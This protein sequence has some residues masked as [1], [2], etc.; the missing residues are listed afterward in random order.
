[1]ILSTKEFWATFLAF[2]RLHFPEQL[3]EGLR[4]PNT[5]QEDV[6]AEYDFII[7][8]AGS[9][10]CVL[11]NRLS[12][13]PGW[14][15][16]LIEAGWRDDYVSD[17]P[18]LAEFLG[19][20]EKDWNYTTVKQERACL[21]TEGTCR[22]PKG[23]VIGGCST[24][25]W[26]IYNRGNREDYDEWERLGNHGWG[27]EQVL[28]YFKKA[29][30]MTEECLLGSNTHSSSGPLNV[31]YPRY[32]TPLRRD[33][34][35]AGEEIGWR[36]TDYNAGEQR[37]VIDYL[38]YTMNGP[39]RES[40]VKAYLDPIRSRKN[41]DIIM[42]SMVSRVLIE[43]N[44]ARGVE[45][46]RDGKAY[47][48]FAK[49]EVIL[50]TGAIETP[51]L[52]ML[53]GIGPSQELKKH[54]IG[55]LVDLPV[56]KYYQDHINIPIYFEVNEL[57][58]TV[59]ES[60]WKTN[61]SIM[62]FAKDKDGPLTMAP[63]G[64]EATSFFNPLEKGPPSVQTIYCSAAPSNNLG[65]KKIIK[66]WVVNIQP[67]S[68]GEIRLKSGDFR[69]PPLLD[70]NL[71]R[72]ETDK[73]VLEKGIER[74]FEFM[75]SETMSKYSPK[76][77]TEHVQPKCHGKEGSEYIGCAIAEYSELTDRPFGTAR[78]GPRGSDA[79][80]SSADL[81]VRGL[82]QLRV[83]DASV[84]P[85][86]PGANTNAP[87]IMIAEKAADIIRSYYQEYRSCDE[88]IEETE[89]HE[90]TTTNRP[91]P[92]SFAFNHPSRKPN[93]FNNFYN[94]LQNMM[95]PKLHD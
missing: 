78:M 42:D 44:V 6:A 91:K 52:L 69:N 79:V 27:Y 92:P 65:D 72:D 55:V 41:V 1:M 31:Q 67:L 37:N 26:M 70:P 57:A 47:K 43:D 51:K 36:F 10:G 22:A 2:L 84:M 7:A 8:G 34:V 11:A 40:T 56:G 90:E 46:Y 39:L 59:T 50:S 80:V 73:K 15:V 77:Y 68:V 81:T 33:Y 89:N 17:T 53:S 14:K 12:E 23:R 75:N 9:A 19:N 45:Y 63:G 38:Q 94:Q 83:V 82:R 74:L 25:N 88:I 16:L 49:K 76:L 58:E 60:I 3:D 5:R 21:S 64:T 61:E 86:N 48:V 93:I 32:V 13:N 85:K 35:R 28:P 30:N 4:T 29:E 20:T 62:A 24:I 54:D 18:F 66:A 95:K 71:F 87:V